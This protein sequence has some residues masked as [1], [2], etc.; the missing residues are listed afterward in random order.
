MLEEKDL[1]LLPWDKGKKANPGHQSLGAVLWGHGKARCPYGVM[2][3]EYRWL[4]TIKVLSSSLTRLLHQTLV[5]LYSPL[6]SLKDPD[7]TSAA[8]AVTAAGEARAGASAEKWLTFHWP[9]W[10]HDCR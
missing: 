4:K 3:S 1:L 7:S 8:A 2:A 5:G 9:N 10:T 6:S